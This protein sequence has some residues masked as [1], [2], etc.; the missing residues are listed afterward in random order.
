M[1][2]REIKFRA[3]LTELEVLIPAE[4]VLG[5]VSEPIDE[6]MTHDRILQYSNLP[7]K[8]GYVV[9]KENS[10]YYVLMQFTGLLDKNGKEIYEGDI[11]KC[12][13]GYGEVIFNAGCFM[14]AW[15]DD[16]EANMEFLFSRKG[17]YVRK[18]DEQFEVIGHKYQD[19]K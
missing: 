11:V 2:K 1:I 7:L 10:E 14:V 5:Y 17:M 18:D 8:G 13:Y 9:E 6:K 16:K 4:Q 12:G 3:W 19:I 15:I